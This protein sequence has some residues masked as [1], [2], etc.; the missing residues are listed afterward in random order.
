LRENKSVLITIFVKNYVK[1]YFKLTFKYFRRIIVIMKNR[2]K[3]LEMLY[4]SKDYVSGTYIAQ[5][6]NISRSAVAKN[7]CFLSGEGYVISAVNKRGYKIDNDYNAIDPLIIEEATG[8]TTKVYNEINSTS[9]RAKLLDVT[10]DTGAIVIARRQTNGHARKGKTFESELGGT[11]FS[12]LIKKDLPLD[13]DT[14]ENLTQPLLQIIADYVH[15]EIKENTVY[16]R[17]K[18]LCGILTES[19]AD[20]DCIHS[21]VLGVGIYPDPLLPPKNKL[22]ISIANAAIAAVEANKLL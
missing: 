10:S 13:L 15:G 22:I 17:D 3:I 16:K 12:V 11:Y 4:A 14:V 8:L 9:D 5:Q 1:T 18:K 21:V 6:L 19:S 2:H 20:E 7:I